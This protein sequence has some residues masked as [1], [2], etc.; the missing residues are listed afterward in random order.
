[1]K[2]ASSCP[3][4][5]PDTS[6]AD[7]P[8]AKT[9]RTKQRRLWILCAAAVLCVAAAAL[10]LLLRA[11]SAAAA[12]PAPQPMQPA[13]VQP[14]AILPAYAPYASQRLKDAYAQN[15]QT[16]GW[17]TLPG[18]A[19]DDPVMQA[20]DNDKY[21]R[22]KEFSADYDVWGCYFLDYI[23]VNDGHTLP[24]RVSMIYGHALDNDPDSEK[25]SKL[26][27]YDDDAFCAQY[28]TLTFSLLYETQVYRIFAVS[29]V[30]ITMDYIDPNPDDAKYQTLL[31][32]L[33]AHSAHDFGVRVTT[34]DRIL[35]LSTC[36]SDPNTRY[37]VAA[38]PQTTA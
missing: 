9:H 19:I 35:L 17:L 11:R 38:V 16:V 13:A 6:P 3:Q 4:A 24:D 21:L 5:V 15:P 18:C 32:Y 36:T 22:R 8:R 14:A 26:K 37:V 31:D 12:E 29:K 2:R 7:P 10:V 23:N 20:A 25:F 1:M 27:R 30:P 33:Y 28:P 34:A